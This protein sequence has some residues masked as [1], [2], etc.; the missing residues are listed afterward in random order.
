[1]R[2][3]P[4]AHCLDG[5]KTTHP[6]Q[7]LPGISLVC[8]N[9]TGRKSR[10]KG[11]DKTVF[12]GLQAWIKRHLLEAWNETFFK[13]DKEEVMEEIKRRL[14]NYCGLEDY[15]HI[16]DL[17]DLGYL[18]VEIRAVPEGTKV[19]VGVPSMMI[20]NTIDKFF[21][22]TNM[23]ETSLSS[24]LWGMI[25]SATIASEYHRV[26]SLFAEETCDDDSMVVFQGHDFSFR[27][28][29]G[30]MAAEMSG[31]GHLT[32]FVGTD[33]VPAID[34]LERY[35]EADVENE[36]VGCSV[37]AT[38]HSGMTTAIMIIKESFLDEGNGWKSW[39]Y[40]KIM[41][42]MGDDTRLAAEK[43]YLL[44]LMERYPTGILSVVMDS[45]DFWGVITKVLPSIKDEIMARDGKLV[46]R[47]D[48]G[49]PVEITTG[50]P[51][52]FIDD[53]LDGSWKAYENW[54]ET[55]EV[56]AQIEKCVYIGL[57]ETLYEIFGG[58]VNSK[59]YKELDPHIGAIYGDAITRERQNQ[60]LQRL[61]E[62]GFA[63]NNIVLGIGSFCVTPDTPILCSDF[64]WRRAGDL[65]VGQEII[66]FNEDP[67][68]GE[69]RKPSRKYQ[70]AMITVNNSARKDCIRIKCAGFPAI[71]CS[72][73]HPFLVWGS[74]ATRKDFYNE[75][76]REVQEEQLRNAPRGYGLIWK[77]AEELQQG[78]Q[79]AYFGKPWERDESRSAGWLEGIYDGEG[80]V[81][82]GTSGRSFAAWKVSI[83]QNEGPV[84]DRIRDELDSRGFTYYE[85]VTDSGC[86]RNVLTGGFYEHARFLGEIGPVRLLEKS[87]KDLNDLPAFKRG[88]TYDLVSVS[89]IEDIGDQ[90]V[91]SITTSCGTFITNGYLSHNTYQMNTRDTFGGAV[92]ATYVEYE[93]KG[94]NVYK[95]PATGDGSKKS[96]KGLICVYP[97]F[98]VKEECTWE[99]LSDSILQPVYRNGILVTETTLQEVRD[100]IKEIQL[101]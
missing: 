76:P 54:N 44:W 23:L 69:G 16:E 99:E 4:A 58:T 81:Y 87:K 31:A 25:N 14:G 78:D 98:T 77:T 34:F 92:K 57:I 40:E 18:P 74:R 56:P 39:S 1:M 7:Y 33:T 35:Y 94:I 27:G 26:F 28:M 73:D 70:T 95:D 67:V 62:K 59:G 36:L 47:P 17:H 5:Y 29:F 19:P 49:D 3:T 32:S 61:M 89:E 75:P 48:T 6:F 91:A 20:F 30:Q 86:M 82:T 42:G 8:S 9:Y 13:R 80:T 12:F 71:E 72:K 65:E 46:C 90:E 85:N 2:N 64:Q 97:D 22:V 79:I 24:D 83:S 88:Y 15:Q 11:I 100:R 68:Y 66:A 52:P 50:K 60:I 53:Q 21:W 101:V 96:L 55:H 41:E 63:S 51:W 10:I 38:E 37:V 45:Y 93:G 84:L 43:A